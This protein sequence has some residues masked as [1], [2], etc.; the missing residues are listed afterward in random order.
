M[1]KKAIVIGSGVGGLSA[2]IRLAK[3]GFDVSIFEANSFIGG[4]VN[5]KKI[6]SYR[7]DMGPSVFTEPKLI[8]ELVNLCGKPANFFRYRKLEES[9]RY[10]YDDGQQI[11]LKRGKS[12]VVKTLQ[13]ELDEDPKR[14][15]A[16]L[17]R[18]K[19]NYEAIYP[20][21][22]Q[23]SLHRFR[24]WLNN[25][26]WKAI[27]RIPKYGLLSTMH[28]V[29]ESTFKNPKTIQIFNRLATYNGSSPYETPGMLNIIS[30]LELNEGPAMP[31]GGMVS[32]TE[33]LKKLADD[34]NIQFHTNE[35]VQ[36]INIR[37]NCVSGI[38]TAKGTYSCDLVVSNMDVHYTYERLL[39]GQTAP[40][41]ILN[42]EK[43]TSAIVFYWG[44]KNEFKKLGVH[45]IFFSQN[46]QA[47]FKSLFETKTMYDDPTIYV[48]I[49][50]K[51]E[52]NDAPKGSENWFVMVNAP[53]NIEQDWDQLVSKTRERVLRKISKQLQTSIEPFIEEEEVCDPRKIDSMYFGK[54]GSIYGNSS[55]SSFSAFYRHP[56]FSKK[57]K[58]LYF[59]GV[60]VHPGGGIP[61]ALNSAKIVEQCVREDF[62]VKQ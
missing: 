7:F 22:I 10:F 17:E 5:S 1:K 33:T 44:I 60:T 43:S 8:D 46:Y 45:N 14:T 62:H 15:S 58:G 28:Q 40:K 59:S 27:F 61:L 47:E 38:K 42:Q 52:K 3:I 32:I 9:C 12:E 25:S 48:H 23:V 26:L 51:V 36:E 16:F 56:N 30:H 2:G 50:S 29:N 6:G 18:M 21:F 39:K 20:V 37:K 35:L 57:I 49:T 53:I 4:K 54:Q 13:D 11:N 31:I 34:C 24:H 55:N 19:S 41:K